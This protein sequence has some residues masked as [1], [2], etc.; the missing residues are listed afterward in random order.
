MLWPSGLS[1]CT[2]WSL[3]ARI[4][5]EYIILKVK[6]EVVISTKRWYTDVTLS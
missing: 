2:V 6:I 3:K 1:H 4:S 5:E